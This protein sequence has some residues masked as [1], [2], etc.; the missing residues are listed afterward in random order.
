MEKHRVKVTVVKEYVFDVESN[1]D[2]EAKSK[3]LQMQRDIPLGEN[4][5]TLYVDS[6]NI[7]N[8]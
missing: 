8:E 7:I 6:V 2:V 1:T 3:A 5:S 4:E